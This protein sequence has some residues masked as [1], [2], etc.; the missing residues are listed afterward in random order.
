MDG[1][2][3][4]RAYSLSSSPSED[5][6]QFSVKRVEGGKVSNYLNDQ[7]EVGQRIT[8]FKPEGKFIVLP[9]ADKTKDHYFIAAGSGITPV[10]SMI[11]TL[12]EDEE[13]STVYLLYGSRKEEDIIF[14]AELDRLAS[15]YEGQL[16]I[17]HT[18]SQ[19][20]EKRKF[21]GILGSKDNAAWKGLKG[22]I[23]KDKLDY[24]LKDYP[25]RSGEAHYYL[26]GPGDLI[27]M[28]EQFL[29]SQGVAEPMMHTE[30]FTPPADDGTSTQAESSGGSG[31]VS[32]TLDGETFT[33]QVDEK[34]TILEAIIDTGKNPP[35]SC[36][37]GACA[38][39]M[40]KTVSGEVSMDSCLSLDD[41]EIENGF[42]LTCQA[43]PVGDGV[44]ISYDDL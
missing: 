14:K 36:T 12:L 32:V 3:E 11:K 42:I 7:I 6:L 23:D 44:S 27:Q 2:A 39:C 19:V 17:S 21:L 20:T 13:R 5:F 34:K 26:C 38:S 37:S 33:V 31:E 43:H 1:Q 9:E 15:R 30:Y 35:Y 10:L 4:R 29:S 41:D 25:T 18:L 22:R 16:F 28:A 40:A 8:T 24:F